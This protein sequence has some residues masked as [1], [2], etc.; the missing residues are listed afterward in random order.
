[1]DGE[2]QEEARED[3]EGS[4]RWKGVKTTKGAKTTKVAGRWRKSSGGVLRA[5]NR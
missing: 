1:M 2:V 4:G 5:V 3:D